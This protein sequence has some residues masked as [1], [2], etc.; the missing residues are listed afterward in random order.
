MAAFSL[1]R[2]IGYPLDGFSVT[3][4]DLN[5]NL[6]DEKFI[7]WAAMQRFKAVA[8]DVDLINAV[9]TKRTVDECVDKLMSLNVACRKFGLE[10]FGSWT[11]I[12]D[13][14]VNEPEDE[15]LTFCKAVR[16]KNISV[17][18]DGNVFIC[19]HTNTPLG[20]LETLSENIKQNGLYYRLVENRLPGNDK[21]CLGC[22]LEGLCVGQ[23]QITKE[24]QK[25]TD[26]GR[27]KFLC[28]FYKLATKRLLEDKL[29]RE[30]E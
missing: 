28:Q 29:T 25:A 13:N 26:N 30:L 12:Y 20:S 1:F 21:D 16:G 10:N 6:V 14:L 22:E 27:Y 17:N 4:N 18:T 19:G 24:V 15:V 7:E 9:N 3:I 8:T 2:D 5:F 23:C 11:T